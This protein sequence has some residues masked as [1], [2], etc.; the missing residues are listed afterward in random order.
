MPKNISGGL[1]GSGSSNPTT[2]FSWMV[3]I[4][5]TESC[6]PKGAITLE[7]TYDA[8]AASMGMVGTGGMTHF[9]FTANEK[10]ISGSKCT[11]GFMYAQPWNVPMGW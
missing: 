6:G 10:A 2:G 11:I 1:I 8:D 5:E 4:D 9:K 3:S 7:Q